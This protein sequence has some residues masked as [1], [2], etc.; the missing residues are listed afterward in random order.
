M[1]AIGDMAVSVDMQQAS[2][3]PSAG[4]G[5][6]LRRD[7]NGNYYT[8]ELTGGG[9]LSVSKR[10]QGQWLTLVRVSRSDAFRTSGVNRLMAVAQG[11]HFTFY[12]NGH[13]VGEIED[14]MSASGLAGVLIDVDANQQAGF[15][16]SNFELRAP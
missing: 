16:F 1:K 15:D 11:T 3:T 7:S 9:Q 14:A 2:G 4:A 12:L 6:F 13:Q 8:F 5:L 10:Q